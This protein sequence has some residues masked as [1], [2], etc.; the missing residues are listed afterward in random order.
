MTAKAG[1][2]DDQYMVRFPE[3]LRDKIKE[4]AAANGRSMNS[5][6]IARLEASFQD[7]ISP[8]DERLFPVFTEWVK[9]LQQSGW[10]PPEDKRPFITDLLNPGPRKLDL[11]D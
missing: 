1:R 6:I 4:V 5:E 11:G 7:S 2:H 9:W 3:G 10:R 8:G